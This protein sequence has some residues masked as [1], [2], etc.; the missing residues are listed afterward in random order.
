[1][2]IEKHLFIF[3][4]CYILGLGLITLLA[5]VL[6]HTLYSSYSEACRALV[7]QRLGPSVSDPQKQLQLSAPLLMDYGCSS[8]RVP[9]HVTLVFTNHKSHI[10][11]TIIQIGLN[12]GIRSCTIYP[13]LPCALVNYP[14]SFFFQTRSLL[15]L[16][17]V[18]TIKQSLG[19]EICI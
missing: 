14:H 7:C 5:A 15:L 8:L 10:L 4:L 9:N 2:N 17:C 19:T 6:E 18:K 11:F 3:L 1:M 16:L 13:A 12:I